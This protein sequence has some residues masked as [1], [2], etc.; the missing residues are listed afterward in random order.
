MYKSRKYKSPKADYVTLRVPREEWISPD[1]YGDDHYGYYD[2]NYKKK[3]GYAYR[4]AEV[5]EEELEEALEKRTK[6]ITEKEK[7]ALEGECPPGTVYRSAY[8]KESG[9]VVPPTCAKSPFAVPESPPLKR[10]T[11]RISE[12]KSIEI[13]KGTSH[14]LSQEEMKMEKSTAEKSVEE[15]LKKYNEDELPADVE[16]L[17]PILT[18]FYKFSKK[19]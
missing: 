14:R 12:R 11:V 1:E 6:K 16:E 4:D 5:S 3:K 8:K 19:L 17:K 9:S 2:H 13:P 10:K 7:E 18:E 15:F